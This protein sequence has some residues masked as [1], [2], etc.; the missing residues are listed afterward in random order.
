MGV[1]TA[2]LCIRVSLMVVSCPL[3]G[4]AHLVCFAWIFVSSLA[5]VVGLSWKV[6]DASSSDVEIPLEP[7]AVVVCGD[8]RGSVSGI[9]VV[10]AGRICGFLIGRWNP[11]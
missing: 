1:L 7:Q 2:A 3:E 10:G 6:G 5:V 4:S 11:D 9:G 8:G